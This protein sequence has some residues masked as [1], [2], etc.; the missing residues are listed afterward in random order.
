MMERLPVG[1]VSLDAV[2]FPGACAGVAPS[3][4]P[5]WVMEAPVDV[6]V[7]PIGVVQAFI[8]A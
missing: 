4:V 8:Q 3:A 6:V 5:S 7:K 2:A 1:V